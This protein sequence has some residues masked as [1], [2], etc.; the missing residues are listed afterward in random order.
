MPHPLKT[1]RA[2]RHLTQAE[3][4]ELAKVSDSTVARIE[5][6]AALVFSLSVCRIAAALGVPVQ[7][8]VNPGQCSTELTAVLSHK[9]M[10]AKWLGLDPDAPGT[11]RFLDDL[12]EELMNR[13]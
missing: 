12:R 13:G 7:D 10:A 3:L 8:I 1:L 5:S 6:G 2:E 9:S 4:A 11:D